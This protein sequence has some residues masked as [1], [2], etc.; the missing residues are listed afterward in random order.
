MPQVGFE[1]TISSGERPQTY[2]LDRAATG[3]G[4]SNYIIIL[5]RNNN[6]N[7][8][9]LIYGRLQGLIL[10]FKIPIGMRKIFIEIY[11]RIG[12]ASSNTFASPAVQYRTVP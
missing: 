11:R 10:L 4:N 3:T 7:N 8:N 9:S 12:H 2:A 5:Y 6:N 1:P